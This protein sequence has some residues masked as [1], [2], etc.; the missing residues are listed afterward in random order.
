MSDRRELAKNI[1]SLLAGGLVG[2]ILRFIAMVAVA[3]AL[4]AAGFG[5]VTTVMGVAYVAA[6]V[7]DSGL[8]QFATREIARAG[9]A[10]TN[11]ATDVLCLKALLVSVTCAAIAAAIF[12]LGL[13]A[14]VRLISVL[15]L[16]VVVTQESGFEWV[17]EGTGRVELLALYRVIMNLTFAAG[18]FLV[19]NGPGL[20]YTIPVV[21][22][23]AS[24]LGF[25]VSAAIAGRALGVFAGRP[26]P[27]AWPGLLRAALPM[28]ISNLLMLSLPHLGPFVMAA[29]LGLGQAGVL[30][31]AGVLVFGLASVGYLVS[32][33]VYPVV[34]RL[35]HESPDSASEA[36]AP[37]FRLLFTVSVPAAFGT[38]LLAAPIMKLLFD[39]EYAAAAV[40]LALLAWA[41]PATCAFAVCQYVLMAC[42]RP[43]VRLAGLLVQV[44][45]ELSLAVALVGRFGLAGVA[46]AHVAGQWL[47]LG[48][49]LV[50]MRRRL[51]VPVLVNAARPFAASLLMAGAVLLLR[52]VGIVPATGAGVAT[53]GVALWFLGGLRM[54][55]FGRTFR[56]APDMGQE[57]KP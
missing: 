34:S 54:E 57:R 22:A 5:L 9:G 27:V 24:V 17:F 8:S 19:V 46:V 11:V 37:V 29:A 28:G 7:A 23:L 41:L 56:A 26:R 35:A 42:R 30:R 1:A 18:V 55:D 43:G 10:R 45:V 50:S 39:P 36:L 16:L 38:A 31:A 4:G 51:S 3:N 49:V 33:A 52:D 32:R 6:M 44:I 40:P 21:E 12:L 48:Y 53:Y 13:P 15:A 25:A 20:A 14:E 2:K 47:G